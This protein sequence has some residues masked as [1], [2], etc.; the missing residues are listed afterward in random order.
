MRKDFP[1]LKKR[2][3]IYFDN[4]ATSQKPQVV[5][6]AVKNYYE[7]ANANVHRGIY[8]LSEKATEI[9]E[10]GRKKV[11]KFINAQS[12]REIIFVRNTTEALNLLAFTLSPKTVTTTIME[13]HSN[14]LP[15][16]RIA[17]LN[18]IDIT[19]NF[20]LE[21]VPSG[22]FIALTHAS[23]VLG[24]INEIPKNKLVVV[25]GAQYIPHYK[26]DV[27]ALGCSA[28]AFSGH[29]MFGPMG[30]GVLYIK[31]ELLKTLPPFM[32]GG[33]MYGSDYPQ[34]FEA[35][36]PDVAGVVGLCAAI[37]YLD[38]EKIKNLESETLS[39]LL[40]GLE[41][42]PEITVY[43]PKINRVP[44]V[45]FNIKSVHP[46]DVAQF[47]NDK[48]GIAVRAGHHCT[49]LLH[50]RLGIMASVRASLSFYNTEEEVEIFLKG[51]KDCI[52][53]FK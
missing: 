14:Y 45:S 1:I 39:L 43:G 38:Y 2:K 24:T 33:G 11:A 48:Y 52:K 26:V 42:I 36:T 16:E 47:L 41:K 50:K 8:G 44:A 6:E 20:E 12:S 29:K 25:D 46:H 32:V 49:T 13:H 51:V 53:T 18:V 17:K 21:K 22:D 28:Y 9:F 31:E 3:L 30:I 10:S 15:W 19:E 27:Q 23:N 37:D 35:G 5:I 40:S 7:T 4:A 34:K